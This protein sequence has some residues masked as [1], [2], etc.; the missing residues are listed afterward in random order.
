[1]LKYKRLMK[2]TPGSQDQ[3][4]DQEIIRILRDMGSFKSKYPTVLHDV[5]R[6]AFMAQVEQISKGGISDEL[7]V[8]NQKGT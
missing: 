4:R 3:E 7:R 2:L 8:E 6:A 5:R 1:M